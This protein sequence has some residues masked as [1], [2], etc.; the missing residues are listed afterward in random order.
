[1]AR[2]KKKARDLTT[3]EALRKLFPAEVRKEA[4][5]EVRK[6]NEQATKKDSKEG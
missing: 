2:P 1:M 3:K 5:K 6:A 4:T